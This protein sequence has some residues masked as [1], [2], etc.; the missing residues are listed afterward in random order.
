MLSKQYKKASISTLLSG[1]GVMHINLSEGQAK[2]TITP[3]PVLC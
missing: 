2:I 1:N 3:F